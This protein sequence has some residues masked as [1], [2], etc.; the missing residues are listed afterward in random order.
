MDIPSASEETI[1]LTKTTLLS[2]VP[3]VSLLEDGTFFS[4]PEYLDSLSSNRTKHL[5]CQMVAIG[6]AL[7][8]AQFAMSQSST[9]Q[10]LYTHSKDPEYFD[11][12][13][14][15]AALAI[16][17]GPA[18]EPNRA[19]RVRQ[20]ANV[21][22]ARWNITM[23]TNAF[24]EAIWWRR[25]AT[26]VARG[27]RLATTH[28]LPAPEELPTKDLEAVRDWMSA[29]VERS[30]AEDVARIRRGQSHELYTNLH[31]QAHLLMAWA[32]TSEDT[33]PAARRTEGL[34]E[35][36]DCLSE[37]VTLASTPE[38][39][40]E[41]HCDVGFVLKV[42]WSMSHS[43]AALDGSVKSLIKA[44]HV[45]QAADETSTTFDQGKIYRTLAEMFFH[46]YYSTYALED[47]DSSI[48][49]SKFELGL[50]LKGSEVFT[51]QAII[52]A[53]LLAHRANVTLELNYFQAIPQQPRGSPTMTHIEEAQEWIAA[54][55]SE[56]QKP[57]E[58]VR[59]YLE[60]VRGDLH[61]I[62]GGEGGIDTAIAIYERALLAHPCKSCKAAAEMRMHAAIGRVHKARLSRSPIDYLDAIR[63]LDESIVQ[64]R[65]HVRP[66][67]A[68]KYVWNVA[69]CHDDIFNARD[70]K[71]IADDVRFRSG[72][73]ALDTW[74]QLIDD[75]ACSDAKR[76]QALFS[77]GRLSLRLLGDPK[78]AR[79]QVMR[80]VNCLDEATLLYSSRLEQ[81]RML[82]KYYYLPGAA[83]AMSLRASDDLPTAVYLFEKA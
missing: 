5:I 60:K 29:T 6:N 63:A 73:V 58:P 32:R 54:A 3:E 80:A 50:L 62:G 16:K 27:M 18:W 34:N 79:D 69:E 28:P 52:L 37:A 51:Q 25:K 1:E 47:L 19:M 70:L 7:Q 43:R 41:V 78:L 33:E 77:L 30:S 38:T 57:T 21:F 39:L 68:F 4:N 61:I 22:N 76:I 74:T 42:Q 44:L 24:E 64:L 49:Y 71:C 67:E 82:R 45:A 17:Y 9:T 11:M 81:L 40:W 20:L 10:A 53:G 36:K 56:S 48:K 2:H 14:A 65:E 8:I 46:R 72:H 75:V 23:G 15:L 55:V 83:L 31:V 12:A 59:M 66:Y 35:A 26:D 13:R